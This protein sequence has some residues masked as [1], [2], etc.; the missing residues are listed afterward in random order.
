MK[1][2]EKEELFWFIVLATV[3]YIVAMM[4]WKFL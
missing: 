2:H 1:P 3:V 4:Q